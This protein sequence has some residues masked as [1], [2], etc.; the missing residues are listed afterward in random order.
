MW[1][2][3]LCRDLLLRTEWDAVIAVGQTVYG[4]SI[5]QLP[6]IDNLHVV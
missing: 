5:A 4:D 1:G 3:F 6:M 2:E